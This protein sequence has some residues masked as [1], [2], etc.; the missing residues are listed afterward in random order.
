[1]A[2]LIIT[3]YFLPNSDINILDELKF[4]PQK[5]ERYETQYKS[6]IVCGHLNIDFSLNCLN[7]KSCELKDLL[8]LSNYGLKQFVK[9]PTYSVNNLNIRQ[10]IIDLFFVSNKF[11][12]NVEVIPNISN[13]CDHFALLTQ[14][15]I[16]VE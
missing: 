11:I 3:I 10:S 14:F 6:I 13:S 12:K 4:M 7:T 16:E 8:I 2:I 1:M 15:S 5:I 9:R